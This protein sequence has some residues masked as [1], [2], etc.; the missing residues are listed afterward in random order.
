MKRQTL[1]DVLF[2]TEGALINNAHPGF[3][4]DYLALHSL[5][6]RYKPDSIFEIGTN[7]GGGLNV[8]GASRPGA[9]IWSLD[10]DYESMMKNPKEFPIGGGGV[11]RT[12]S[13]ARVPFIQIRADSLKFD[14]ATIPCEAYFI[15][16]CHDYD[17]PL[18]ESR[19]VIKQ[20]PRLI[21]WHDA[22][23]EPVFNAICDAFKG[24]KDYELY[25]VEGTRI[26]YALRK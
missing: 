26:A 13:G 8:I 5:L 2:E 21:I 22:D 1:S 12:G 4:E 24:N 14:Y 16:G 23:M 3:K 10:L 6:R 11:D 25:R 17:H 18:H 20:N 9:K 19:E 15:D 7:T